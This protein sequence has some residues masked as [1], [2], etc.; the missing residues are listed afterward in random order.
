MARRA[1]RPLSVAS[2]IIFAFLGTLTTAGFLV[3]WIKHLFD[4]TLAKM[5][6][7]IF[8]PAVGLGAV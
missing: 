5:D 8:L 1:T 7:L 4:P 2:G 3:R 6:S